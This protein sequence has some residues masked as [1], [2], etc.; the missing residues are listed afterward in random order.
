MEWWPARGV[1]ARARV[2]D[3]ELKPLLHGRQGRGM[4]TIAMEGILMTTQIDKDIDSQKNKGRMWPV[5]TCLYESACAFV[6]GRPFV[7]RRVDEDDPR[8]RVSESGSVAG[9]GACYIKGM[10]RS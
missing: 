6:R 1:E 7:N 8:W 3:D 10:E 2:N 4:A 9:G 5:A